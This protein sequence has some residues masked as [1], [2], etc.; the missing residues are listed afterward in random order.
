MMGWDKLDRYRWH[1]G[2]ALEV[3][4]LG[5]VEAEFVAGNACTKG[6]L[7]V[8]CDCWRVVLVCWMEG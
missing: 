7:R 4:V 6:W 8:G 2:L 5:A 3:L 1:P